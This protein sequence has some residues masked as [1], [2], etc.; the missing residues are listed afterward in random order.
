ML[1][2]FKIAPPLPVDRLPP[3]SRRWCR[4][5]R[6]SPCTS[7]NREF[8]SG[9]MVRV[10]PPVRLLASILTP[11]VSATVSFEADGASSAIV[12]P[13]SVEVKAMASK[14]GAAAASSA[15]EPASVDATVIVDAVEKVTELASAWPE[16]ADAGVVRIRD[17]EGRRVGGNDAISP[18]SFQTAAQALER[19]LSCFVSAACCHIPR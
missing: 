7:I 18:T 11:P 15:G 5:R 3:V 10:S 2:S 9:T 13:L 16:R 19:S 17:D 14:P 4:D 8:P 6:A 1:L 12:P